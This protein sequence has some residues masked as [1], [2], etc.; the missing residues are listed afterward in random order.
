MTDASKD[1]LGAVILQAEGDSWRP[2]AY[3]SRMMTPSECRYALREKECLGSV[4][5]VE[6]FHSYVYRFPTFVAEIDHK[7]LIAII[8]KNLNQTSQRIQRLMMRLQRYDMEVVYIQ[9]K[10]IVLADSLSRAAIQGGKTC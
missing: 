3:A 10:Y 8:K 4:Y 5:G 2:V 9:R 6:R 7:P 1:G